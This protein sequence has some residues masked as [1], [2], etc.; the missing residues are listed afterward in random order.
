MATDNHYVASLISIPPS[1]KACAHNK[2]DPVGL[3]TGENGAAFLTFPQLNCFS[4]KM[5]HAVFTRGG[6]FS[7]FPFNSLNTSM[8]NGDDP[9]AVA[10]NRRVIG[11]IIG[12]RQIVFP[13]QVHADTVAVLSGNVDLA[14]APAEIPTADALITDIPGLFI[15]IQIADC[16]AVMLYDPENN[17]VANIHSGWKGSVA[18]I[19]GKTVAV[20]T[21]TFGTHA[22]RL[23][24][25]IGPS[26][27]PCC[28]EFVNYHDEIPE[29]YWEYMDHRC[30]FDFW[31]IS[32]EQLVQAGVPAGS[33]ENHR[34][35]TKCRTDYFYSYR[36]EK[37]TGRFTAL[38]GVRGAEK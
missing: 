15:A 11:C 31:A 20:M 19:I 29:R 34:I 3:E 14:T 33:I 10:K 35:C 4:K 6:G 28:A 30:C 23:K 22:H 17:A 8:Q 7:R 18:N 37:E 12:A 38:I 21:K 24:A 27:G 1:E 26:L 36:G 25:A 5:R 16:Q 32:T 2:T 13:R 9:E